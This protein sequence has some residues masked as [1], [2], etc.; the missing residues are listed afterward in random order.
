[1]KDPHHS[2]T[3]P[4][5]RIAVQEIGPRGIR[6]ALELRGTVLVYHAK[7]W[8]GTASTYIPVEWVEVSRHWRMR[9]R[10][11]VR[12]GA[13]LGA[14]AAAGLAIAAYADFLLPLYA[15]ALFA[16]ML[17]AVVAFRRF[18][19]GEPTVRFDVDLAPRQFQ[20]ECWDQPGRHSPLNRLTRRITALQ[21]DLEDHVPYPVHMT[22]QWYSVRPWRASLVQAA[23]VTLVLAWPVHYGATL[24]DQPAFLAF[25]LLPS[26]VYLGR[27]AWNRLMLRFAPAEF[28]Q[29]LRAHDRQDY[30]AAKD[31]LTRYLESNPDQQSALMLLSQ[32]QCRLHD[33][34]AALRTC[35][36]FASD[37]PETAS[38]MQ[39]EILGMQRMHQR[40]HPPNA[41]TA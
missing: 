9:P 36:R 40:M 34:T 22:Y 14:S 8:V 32:T 7:T 21:R 10:T 3:H 37:D 12:A 20:I 18:W 17:Y 28:R 31:H 13:L 2:H 33:Y 19:R 6:S 39:D 5:E 35:D 16:V 25:L 27:I 23:L 24:L 1:M 26:A 4:G 11:L 29:A 15:V 41:G 38:H 30:R